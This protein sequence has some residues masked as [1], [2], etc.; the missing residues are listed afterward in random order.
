MSFQIINKKNLFADLSQVKIITEHGLTVLFNS[1]Q[2]K[3]D[4]LSE[5]QQQ[6]WDRVFKLLN[7]LPVDKYY[8]AFFKNDKANLQKI[9]HGSIRAQNYG[10]GE[11]LCKS[12][13]V[14]NSFVMRSQKHKDAWADMSCWGQDHAAGLV[15]YLPMIT[16][17]IYDNQ[18]QIFFDEDAIKKAHRN[19]KN[20]ASGEYEYQTVDAI[21]SFSEAKACAIFVTNKY[22]EGYMDPKGEFAPLAR[23]R[24][25]ESAGAAARAISSSYRFSDATIVHLQTT[26][27]HLD[28]NQKNAAPPSGTLQDAVALQ[29][30]KRLQEALENATKEDLLQR[31]Q[32][33]EEP[34]KIE[35]PQ[36]KRKM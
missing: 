24:L 33:F 30:R 9:D 6:Q 27:L 18:L 36:Q 23:A 3:K 31:L 10:K 20:F 12:V 7:A 15:P 17:W 8:M 25:F 28:T 29:E 16:Q 34:Q 14:V 35:P 21:E 5:K 22:G 1:V 2:D 26:L 32:A 11:V 13:V 4:T 19:S